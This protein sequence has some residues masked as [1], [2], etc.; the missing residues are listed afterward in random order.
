MRTITEMFDLSGRTAVVTGA[1]YGLGLAFAQGLAA[2][3]ARVVLAARS[4]DKLKAECAAIEK[5]GGTA[6]AVACDVGDAAQVAALVRSAMER[7]GRVDI[8]VNNAGV[9]P[10]GGMRPEQIP[11]QV[12]EEAVRVNLLGVWHGCREA[13]RAMLADGKG[14]SII[15]VASIAGLMG[16][17][18]WPAAYQTTKA[19]VINMTRNLACS[20]ADRGV[21]VNALAPGWFP[22]EMTGAALEMPAIRNWIDEMAPMGRPGRV[23][24][25]VPMLLYL[26]SDASSFVTGAVM[27][28]DGGVSAKGAAPMPEEY[29]E[30][31]AAA[32]LGEVTRRIG[33]P[34]AKTQR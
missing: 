20:W 16:V 17:A 19:A 30:A 28:V 34:V 31:F 3:G 33:L 12:F 32:G 2:Q 25:L 11:P 15:N 27:V 10:E 5:A 4:V 7:F 24:E 8:M 13:G 14:G 23:E 1:S 18:D 29:F 21:R 22:S 26:A 6:L 9:V